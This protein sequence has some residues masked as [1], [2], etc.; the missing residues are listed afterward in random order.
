MGQIISMRIGRDL[1]GKQELEGLLDEMRISDIVR[2]KADFTPPASFSR[3]YGAQAP[4]KGVPNGPPLLFSGSVSVY[5]Y[6]TGK[7]PGAPDAYL[8]FPW[9]YVRDVNIRPGSFMMTSRDGVNWKIY[10]PPYYF[11]AGGKLNGRTI[12]EALME[13]GMIQRGD[14]IWQYGTVRFTEHGGALY[15]G[16]EH[17]GGYFD[18]LLRLVQRLDGFVSLDA[19]ATKG[20]A[21]TRPLIFG[22]NGLT[23]NVAAKG[24]ARVALLDEAG[25]ALP[26]FG[27][28]DCD[29][30]RVDSVRHVVTWKGRSDVT[31]LA[32]KPVSLQFE[33]ANAKLYA[34][35]FK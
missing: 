25:K 5:R 18:S 24:S 10:E 27:L 15:G 22:G 3:N 13:P 14:E 30:I 12:L 17:E 1:D 26:G 6:Y 19:G 8:A 29:P 7:Y 34:F 28:L 4:A 23:L 11:S 9:R 20:S 2:Y 21:T 16:V 33:L 32:G 35:Q 31:A